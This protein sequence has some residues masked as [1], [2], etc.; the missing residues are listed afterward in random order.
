M[1]ILHE[2]FTRYEDI[3]FLLSATL[4]NKETFDTFV[5]ACG[6]DYSSTV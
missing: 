3:K 4:R 1:L 6:K 5:H 2:I